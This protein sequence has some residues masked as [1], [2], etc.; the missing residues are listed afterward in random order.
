MYKAVW[1]GDEWAKSPKGTP[2]TPCWFLSAVVRTGYDDDA[3]IV[4]D[5]PG[6]ELPIR[7]VRL[8]DV[9]LLRRVTGVLEE[10]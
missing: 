6:V 7:T 10:N 2:P 3:V 9:K 4:L 1:Y 5:V 8:K